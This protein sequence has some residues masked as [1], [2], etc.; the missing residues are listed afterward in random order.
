MFITH[1]FNDGNFQVVRIPAELASQDRNTEL[2]I[3]NWGQSPIIFIQDIR[4]GSFLLE[5]IEVEV[6]NLSE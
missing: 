1:L 2:L 5:V 3:K 6:I 4:I